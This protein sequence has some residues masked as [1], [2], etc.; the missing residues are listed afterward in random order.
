V[1]GKIGR[2]VKLASK[3][4]EKN[5]KVTKEILSNQDFKLNKLLIQ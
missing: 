2:D 4:S 5:I 1:G 3:I